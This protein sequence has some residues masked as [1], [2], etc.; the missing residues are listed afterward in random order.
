MLWEPARAL[1]WREG[2]F[3]LPLS[4]GHSTNQ[5]S[6]S[7]LISET[8]MPLQKSFTRLKVVWL[9][10]TCPCGSE[11]VGPGC[12]LPMTRITLYKKAL[13]DKG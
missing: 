9:L 5:S 13:I 7:A 4:L 2:C 8:A 3:S 10:T 6:T 11:E 1:A 12:M